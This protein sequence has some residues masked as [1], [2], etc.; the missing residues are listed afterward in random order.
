MATALVAGHILWSTQDFVA[1]QAEPDL[2]EADLRAKQFPLGAA[3]EAV[4]NGRVRYA[5]SAALM[6]IVSGI[7]RSPDPS[8]LRSGECHD[9]A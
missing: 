3:A 7:R 6:L 8:G 1:G 5:A 2:G 4:R 9:A